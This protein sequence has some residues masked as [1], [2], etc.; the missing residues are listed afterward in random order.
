MHEGRG[1]GGGYQGPMIIELLKGA[2][3]AG[4]GGGAIESGTV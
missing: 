1:G 2:G 3:L 4:G